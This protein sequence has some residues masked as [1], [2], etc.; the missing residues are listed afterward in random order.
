MSPA[1]LWLCFLLVAAPSADQSASEKKTADAQSSSSKRTPPDASDEPG[2][3]PTAAKLLKYQHE[4]TLKDIDK[5]VKLSAEVK[6]E[7]EKG[8]ENVLPLATLKK[9]EDIERLSRKIRGRL[10]Q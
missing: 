3:P 2:A 7:V 6:E 8:G 4:E 5:L 9:L 10:K 1:I